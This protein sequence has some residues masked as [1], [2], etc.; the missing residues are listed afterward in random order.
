LGF[1]INLEVNYGLMK[2]L[3]NAAFALIGGRRKDA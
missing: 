2:K 3:N 1:E